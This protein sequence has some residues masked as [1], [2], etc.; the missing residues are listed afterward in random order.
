MTP[1]GWRLF[2]DGGKLHDCVDPFELVK[3]CNSSLQP[4]NFWNKVQKGKEDD[5]WNWLGAVTSSG[6]G[7]F[8]YE[9]KSVTAH[10][11]AAHFTYGTPINAPKNKSGDGFLLH[12]CDNRRCCNPKHLHVGSYRSNQLEAYER[13]RRFAFTGASHANAKLTNK[14]ASVIRVRSALG[15]SSTKLAKEF[16]VSQRTI[17]LIRRG[18]SYV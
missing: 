7:S 16:G 15:E 3:A 5:C 9:G 1:S 14:E 10:R 11:A 2:N 12:A 8:Y 4:E 18:I 13:K 17:S 6:Y